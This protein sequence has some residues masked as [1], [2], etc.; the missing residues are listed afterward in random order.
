MKDFKSYSKPE[1]QKIVVFSGAVFVVTYFSFFS[2][3]LFVT[4]FSFFSFCLFFSVDVGCFFFFFFF[5]KL[6][7][8]FKVLR[9][10]YLTD[11]FGFEDFSS[12]ST[13]H[14]TKKHTL[15][16][17]IF[18]SDSFCQITTLID[19]EPTPQTWKIWFSEFVF[20][21]VWSLVSVFI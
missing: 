11:I 16:Q 12:I 2:F 3:C 7:S 13:I 15:T 20:H 1:I 5:L 10:C 14:S 6:N 8:R 19:K 4:H 21:P 18:W 17:R 9:Y